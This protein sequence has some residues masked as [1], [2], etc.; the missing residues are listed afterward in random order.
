VLDEPT[1]ALDVEGRHEFWTVMRAVAAQG[2]T[3]LFATHYLEEADV[4]ADRIILMARGRVVADGSGTQI[5]AKVGGRTIRATLPGVDP[6]ELSEVPGVTAADRRGDAVVLSCL[7][8]DTALR[9]LLGRYPA[10]HDIEVRAAGL[11]EAFLELTADD[12][13]DRDADGG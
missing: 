9:A 4:Y 3:I 10:A 2:K 8:S 1:V 12:G 11:D 7:D 6:G 13:D 5:K